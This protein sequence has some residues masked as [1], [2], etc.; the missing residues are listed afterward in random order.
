MLCHF[1]LDVSNHVIMLGA[2]KLNTHCSSTTV[3]VVIV[4][5]ERA[6]GAPVPYWI[7]FDEPCLISHLTAVGVRPLQVL[8]RARKHAAN[9]KERIS[10]PGF[11]TQNHPSTPAPY[12]HRGSSSNAMGHILDICS[13]L[14]VKLCPSF[15]AGSWNHFQQSALICTATPTESRD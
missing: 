15:R 9:V 11:F 8:S 4:T 1:N 12:L 10:K 6:T 2:G 7:S 5:K 14:A 13:C 3:F